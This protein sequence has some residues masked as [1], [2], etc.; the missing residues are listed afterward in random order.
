[1]RAMELTA[2]ARLRLVDRAAREPAA[3]EVLIRVEACAVC[4]T[5]VHIADGELPR[6]RPGVIP[7]HQIV[8]RV[9]KGG[10]D[11]SLVRE[12]DRVGVSWLAWT[13]NECRY[14]TSGR[15]NLCPRASFTGCDVD[16]GFAELALADAR[17]C[18]PLGDRDPVA[19]APLL[20][21]GL[22]GYRA[23]E[24]TGDA[25]RI[26]FYGFGSAAHV[27]AQ[28]AV[29]AGRE[30]HAFVRRGDDEKERFARSLGAAWAGPSDAPPPEPLDAAVI[31][32]PAGELV[33][34]ALAAVSPGG[35][36][37]CAGIHMSDIPRFPYELLWGERQ[38]R[39]VANLTR[40]DGARF[41][42]AIGTVDVTTVVRTWPLESAA[43]AI[44][45]IRAGA[46]EGSAVLLP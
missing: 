17:Y 19:T 32:A 11:S 4:R 22:I 37:V 14:C 5:D 13:C 29:A 10:D 27:L 42:R 3:G 12:G 1:M 38:L 24:M 39:S 35:I 20:C 33:P 2:R 25:Q 36:V 18:F 34:R 41:F 16:G 46:I 44:D 21:G 31:F 9:V 30:V 15:E 23:L 26:G 7:G 28:L 45:A 43:E 8:G 6:S 40:N